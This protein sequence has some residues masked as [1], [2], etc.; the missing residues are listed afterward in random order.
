MASL[1]VSERKRLAGICGLFASS[2]D[3]EALSAARMA[4]EFLRSR[5]LSWSDVLHAEPPAPAVVQSDRNWRKAAEQILDDH[6]QALIAW[7][8]R[9][10]QDLLRRGYAP[11]AEQAVVLLRIA[12]KCGVPGWQA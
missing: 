9:F 7:E 6:E 10:V 1:S 12:D 4:D 8:A 11:T 2:S 3:G 5:S